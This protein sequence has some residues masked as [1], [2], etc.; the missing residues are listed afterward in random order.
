MQLALNPSIAHGMKKWEAIRRV[1]RAS[2]FDPSDFVKTDS[3]IQKIEAE[4]AQQQ[5]Q[6]DPRIAVAQIRAESEAQIAAQ[7]LQF[8]A[9]NGERERQ[10]KLIVAAIDE[11]MNSTQITADEKIN[12]DKIK[13][14]LSEK[15][16]EVRAQKEITHNNQLLDLHK[17]NTDVVKK[18]GVEPPGRAP[19]GQGFVQ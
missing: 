5:G 1:V 9:A 16:I 15:V 7:R 11:R 2:R 3:E 18:P 13:A 4:M 14:T 6:Q 12:L 17:H 19:D 10:N 8:E